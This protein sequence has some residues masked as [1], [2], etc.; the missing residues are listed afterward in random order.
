MLVTR[1]SAIHYM[2]AARKAVEVHGLAS[3]ILEY[4]D[5]HPHAVDCIDGIVS[6]WLSS[7]CSHPAAVARV[8]DEL[9]AQGFIDRIA[10]TD[11]RAAYGRLGTR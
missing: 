8:L 4:L 6:Y 10:L 5:T 2:R 11:G 9:A 7:P 3:E 1:P